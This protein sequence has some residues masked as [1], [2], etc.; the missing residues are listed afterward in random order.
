M[1]TPSRTAFIVALLLIASSAAARAADVSSG[2]AKDAKAP[3]LKVFDA[4]G[5]HAGQQIDYAQDRGDKPTVYVFI[6]ADRWGRPIA[7]FLRE[8]DKRVADWDPNAY[9]VA[10]WLSSDAAK[11]KEYLPRAQRSIKLRATALT[12][13]EGDAAGPQPWNIDSRADVTAVVASGGKVAATG[14]YVSVNETLVPGV[15]GAL[16]K[17]KP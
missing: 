17:T 10:V 1:T 7:R 2:P 11:A 8:L 9:V 3:A 14:G 4:T 5:Q 15:F 6:P 13:F 16:K 12:V